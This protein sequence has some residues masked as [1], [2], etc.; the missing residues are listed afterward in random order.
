[1]NDSDSHGH[2][3]RGSVVCLGL[4]A[5]TGMR[6]VGN[7]VGH[8]FAFGILGSDVIHRSVNNFILNAAVISLCGSKIFG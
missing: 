6:S 4:E 5:G 8:T 7:V 2:L 1:V 3:G